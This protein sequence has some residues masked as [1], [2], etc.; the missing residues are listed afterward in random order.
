MG[1]VL[2][3]SDDLAN[4]IAAGEV[5]ERPASVVKEL[6][7]NALD[8]GATR[9]T[10]EV[11]GGGLTL[12]RVTDDGSGMDRADAVLSLERHATSKLRAFDDLL[13]LSSFGFRGEALPSIASVSRFT[14]RTRRREDDEGVEIAVT[15]GQ[16]AAPRPCGLA[17]GTSVEVRDLFFNVPARRKFL[18]SQATESSHITDAVEA[19]ALSQPALSLELLRD[20]RRVGEWLSSSGVADRVRAAFK[21]E[22]LS[23]L[24]GSKGCVDL[25]AFLGRPE[26]ARSASQATRIFVNG[27]LIRDRGIARTV[28]QAY[29]SVLPP[30]R[31]PV[32]V[33]FLSV[34]GDQVDVN[35]HPQKAEVRFAKA[36]DV[37]EAVFGI[38]SL[39]LGRAFGLA[40]PQRFFPPRMPLPGARPEAD[41]KSTEAWSWEGG[42]AGVAREAVLADAATPLLVPRPPEGLVPAAPGAPPAA[43]VP[44]ADPWG[45]SESAPSAQASSTLPRAY[46][47]LDERA[48]DNRTGRVRFSALRYLAQARATYLLCEGDDGLYVID[49]HAAAERVTFHRLQAAFAARAVAIQPL[50]FPLVVD[51]AESDVLVLADHQEELL[52]AGIDARP[53]GTRQIALHGVPQLVSKADPERLLRDLLAEVS[54]QGGRAFSDALDLAL[55]TMACHGS[56]RAGDRVAPEEARALLGALDEVDFSGHCPHGR[57]VITSLRFDELERKVGRR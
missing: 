6:L 2:R 49:Q 51:G 39:E 57:P 26:R 4:Q 52:A 54:R 27:R 23:E 24:S 55:A 21:G 5:V 50:L 16:L 8:A 45:L 31:Y 36:R 9:I 10:V 1:I 53:A 32:G 43:T 34:P 28:L 42:H 40:A 7:E 48:P 18:K 13:S 33:V 11:E 37:T 41:R 20:G 47:P 19:M 25:H 22:D 15:A 14:L 44:E 38:L 30:G 17:V 3:L 29:G 46:P 35:V 12:L 56:L